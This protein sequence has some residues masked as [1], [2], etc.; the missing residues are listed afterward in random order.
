MCGIAGFAG[1]GTLDDLRAMNAAQAHRGPDGEGQ[2]SDAA[3]GLFLGHRRLSII[4]L[5]GGAQPMWSIDG[6]FAIVFNGEIYNFAELRAELSALG[7]RFATDHSDTE[8]LLEA[9]RRWGDECVHRLNGMWAFVL[10]DV[11]R[12]RLFGSRDRFGK[13]P[14]YYL[15]RP[16]LFAFASELTALT[17]HRAIAPAISPLAVKKYF[18]Y[19]YIPAPHTIYE[20]VRKLP[21]GHSFEY[22]LAAGRLREWRYWDFVLEPQDDD[23]AAHERWCDQLCEL[24]AR[25]VKRRLVSDVPIGAFISGGIDSSAVAA[26]A[27]IA[28][29][30]G[31]LNTFSI[32]FHE[33]SFDESAY[34]RRAAGHV[35]SRHHERMLSIDLA[36]ELAPKVL[37]RLDEPMADASILPTYLLSGFARESVTVALGGDGAD[38]LFAGYDPFRALKWASLYSRLVP[39]PVHRAVALVASRLPVSHRNMSLDFRIKRT[40]QGLD[41]PPRLW[42]AAWMALVPPQ[43]LANCVGEP[44]D[45][46]EVYAE[47][48]AAWDEDRS[49]SLVDKTLRFYTKLYLQDDILTK[50]DRASMMHSLEVRAPFLDIELV[51]FV[52][53]LPAAVKLRGGTTKW[54]LK[55]ALRR[56]LP[57]DILYRSKKGFGVPIGEWL[58]TG[59]LPMQPASPMIA[60]AFLRQ[61]ADRHRANRSDERAFLWGVCVL[62]RFR[63]A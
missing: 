8:V 46:E 43:D 31:V 23:P 4:D 52:R 30:R 12:R 33:P 1:A 9:Y 15:D 49:E 54:I 16:G 13:K 5:A 40:L 62:D 17:A 26:Y 35:G 22:D 25:A 3:L 11:E 32:G 53:T 29:G 39:R 45:L 47:A 37:G 10:Y 21:G 58:R 57:D 44:V 60:P 48:I 34:A 24:I 6:R 28:L 55:K 38:E 63:P 20:G 14:L 2:W 42:N 19:G 41:F 61:R 36:R 59:S 7:A 51:D 27:S 56:V 50:V 18:A